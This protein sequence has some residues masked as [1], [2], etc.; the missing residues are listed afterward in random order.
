[1]K[2]NGK[3]VSYKDSLKSMDTEE[4]IDLMFYRPIGFAWAVLFAKLGVKPNAVTIASIFLGVAAGVMFYF[5]NMW[6]NV[7]GMLLLIGISAAGISSAST[8]LSL[9]GFSVVND[10]LP[11]AGDDRKKLARSRWAMLAVS[12][13]VLV[14][15]YLNPPHIFLIMYFGGTVIASAWPSAACGAAV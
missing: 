7:I 10:I 8:F 11:G 9:I 5:S 3:E 4:T 14:L 13:V 6:L 12:L 1:M 15:A 2:I